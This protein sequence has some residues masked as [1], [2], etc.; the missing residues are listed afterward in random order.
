MN[1]IE[2]IAWALAVTD[3]HAAIS[4][5]LKSLLTQSEIKEISS[6][7]ELVKL[8][9]SGMSQRKISRQLG[10][11]LCKITR[12]SKELKKKPSS[13]RKMIDT[14]KRLEEAQ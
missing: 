8:L 11:S 6:R 1:K 7:W 14:Y 4:D 13:F 2:E 10:L 12:G 9:E 3:D 5:F